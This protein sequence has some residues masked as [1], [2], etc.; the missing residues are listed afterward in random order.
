[1]VVKTKGYNESKSKCNFEY[2]LSLC[3]KSTYQTEKWWQKSDYLSLNKKIQPAL[4][5]GQYVFALIGIV[6]NLLVVIIIIHKD[7]KETFKGL[8]HYSYLWINSAFYLIIL[9]I[10]PLSWINECFYPFEAFCPEIRKIPFIQFFKIIFK[11][12]IVTL[13][14]YMCNFTYVAF[15]LNRIA[16]IGKD[17][18]KVVKFISDINIKVYIAVC[19]LISSSLSWIKYFKYQ[20]N[21]FVSHSFSSY[22]FS[23]ELDINIITEYYEKEE[24]SASSYQISERFYFIYN[25]ISDLINYLVFVII[26]IIIDVSMVIQVKQILNEKLKKFEKE[27]KAKYETK[28]KENKD[29]INKLIQMGVINSALGVLLKSPSSF[30]SIVNLYATFYYRSYENLFKDSVFGE[31]YSYLL[32]TGFKTF[33]DDVCE[34]LYIISISILFFIYKRFDKKFLEGY[35]ILYAN[36]KNKNKNNKTVKSQHQN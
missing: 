27:N 30:M 12:V 4:K 31:F 2:R 24:D 22:P 33:I 32:D 9:I 11:E 15:A 6:T 19:F 7:N 26:C 5:I 29:A 1:M 36:E 23:N 14:K 10:W 21:Y 20:V 28:K 25:S 18:N 17:H 13:L 3:N 34:F 35:Q 8:K 16:L